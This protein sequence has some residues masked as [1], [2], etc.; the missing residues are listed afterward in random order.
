MVA[1]L[2]M[3][4]CAHDVYDNG[5]AQPRYEHRGYRKVVIQKED[6]P[7]P[8]EM[9]YEI[10][11][12]YGNRRWRQ[13]SGDNYNNKQGSYG[14]ADAQGISRQVKYIADDKGFRVWVDTNEPGVGNDNPA[15]A[16][17][18][19]REAPKGA[20]GDHGAYGDNR[21]YENAAGYGSSNTHG[22][23]DYGKVV[24]VK[25]A[26]PVKIVRQPLKVIRQHVNIARVPLKVIRQPVR[27]V[28]EHDKEVVVNRYPTHGKGSA[29]VHQERH[30]IKPFEYT[31]VW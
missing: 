1:F 10:A 15:D 6:P 9:N 19:V 21:A 13:E 29:Y 26:Q 18:T 8:Y 16:E 5:Y 28:K 14:Y 27:N 31:S 17:F 23:G 30:G 24:I 7:R 25:E 20:Y 12:D 11:D 22:L 3:G 2:V 4:A